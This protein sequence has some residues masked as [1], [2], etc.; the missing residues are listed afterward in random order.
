MEAVARRMRL[1]TF[2]AADLGGSI[3]R[4][5]SVHHGRSLHNLQSGEVLVTYRHRSMR[6]VPIRRYGVTYSK[7]WFRLS[8][9]SAYDT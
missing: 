7:G 6:R 9:F 1:L 2:A 8:V 4:Q 5:N 3:V